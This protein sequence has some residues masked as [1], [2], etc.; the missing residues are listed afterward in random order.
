MGLISNGDATAY[1]DK[2]CRLAGWCA[3]NYQ[4]LNIKKKLIRDC[5]RHC[6]DLCPLH[7]T[8]VGVE[9]HHRGPH[10]DNQLQCFGEKGSTVVLLSKDS[11]KSNLS[12]KLL[13]PFEL[14]SAESA[15]T[16]CITVWC[17]NCSAADRGAPQTVINSAQ[18][19]IGLPLPSLEDILRSRCLR[20]AS[21]VLKDAAH[22]RHHL[23]SRPPS[24]SRCR[25]SKTRKTAF[26]ISYL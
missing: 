15:L 22:P 13:V 17:A 2:V 4:S 21:S 24:G 26:Q 11:Q 16:Y 14:S 1:R 12:V 8:G 20:R 9:S 10:M 5:G 25:A 18:K 6:E 7:I 3:G 19:I 23:P